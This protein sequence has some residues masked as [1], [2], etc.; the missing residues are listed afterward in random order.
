MICNFSAFCASNKIY[1]YITNEIFLQ[2]VQQQ[3]MKHCNM[4]MGLLCKY[5]ISWV[6]WVAQE[7]I[8]M[9]VYGN[10]VAFPY[11]FL[12][13]GG[14]SGDSI[15]MTWS[16]HIVGEYIEHEAIVVPCLTPHSL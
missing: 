16:C 10:R 12:V 1:I 3:V 9:V 5:C 8:K 15:I 11:G 7:M 4:F 6:M 13:N 2:S 14:N